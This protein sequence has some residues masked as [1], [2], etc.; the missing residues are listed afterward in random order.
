MKSPQCLAGAIFPPRSLIRNSRYTLFALLAV[1]VGASMSAQSTGSATSPASSSTST[2]GKN[3]E[4]LALSPFVVRTERDDGFVAA[5]SLAGGRLGGDLKDTPVAYSVLTRDFIDALGLT[6]LAEMAQWAPNTSEPRNMGNLEWS[7]NDFYLASRGV[8]ANRPQRDFF[9]YGFNFDSYNIE[10][11]DFGRGPNSILFGNS[12]YGS[13]PNIVSKRARPDKRMSE[14]KVSYGSWENFRATLD[15]NQPLGDNAALRFN[16]LHL[17]RKGWQDRDFEKKNSATLAGTWQPLKNTELRFEAE[18]GEKDKAAVASNFDDFI[19][20][21]NGVNTYSA[22][23]SA[24]V[25]AAGIGR[26]ATRTIV[27]TPTNGLDT[28]INYEGWARTEGGNL[29]ASY[30]AGGQ[31]VPGPSA[32]IRNTPILNRLN[33]PATLFDLAENGSNFRVPTREFTTTVDAPLYTEDYY[34]YTFSVTQQFGERLFAEAAVNFAGLD[35]R[36]DIITSRGLTQVYIDVNRVLP[37]GQT[38]PNF[39][40]PYSESRSYPHN[41]LGEARNGRLALAYVLDDT[42][43]GDFRFNVLAGTSRADDDQETWIYVL[44]DNADPRQWPTF[45]QVRFRYYLN[46]DD[47]RPYDTSDRDWTYVNPITNT[48]QTVAGGLVRE[49]G[50]ATSNTESRTEYDYV[51]AAVDAKFFKKRLNLLAAVRRDGYSTLQRVGINQFDYPSTWDGKTL[52]LKPDAPGDW[53]S[54]TYRQRDTAG[55]PV[56]P[57]LLADIRPRLSTGFVDPRYASD[58]FQDDFNAPQIEGAINTFS[59]GG[60]FHVT[61]HVSVF[62]NYAE[63]FVPPIARYDITGRLIDARSAEGYDFGLRFRMLNGRLVANLIRYEGVD[64]GNII[65]AAAYRSE[66]AEIAQANPVGDLTPSGLNARGLPV[67]PNG[68]LDTVK[69]EISGWEF[70]VTANLTKNW[71]L[72]LN[73]ALAEGYQTDTYPTVQAYLAANDSVL[74]QIVQDAGGVFNGDVA[75]YNTAIPVSTSPEGPGAVDA[76]NTTRQLLA[77]ISTEKQKLNRLVEATGNVFTDY[78][79]RTGMLKGLRVGAGAN[80]R[81]KQVIGYRGADT[82]RN[83]ANTAQ[84]IDDPTVGPLDVVYQPAYTTATATLNYNW[85]VNRKLTVDLSLRISNLFDYAKPIYFST[86]LRPP[87]GDLTNPARVSTPVNYFWITPRNYTLSATVKF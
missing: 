49:F 59:A 78:T 42:K 18:R 87:D 15:H 67:P 85:R 51:Q 66:I 27:F 7:N 32:N 53:S 64:K 10:R 33:L 72:T 5:T 21:W 37:N 63:S 6:D 4:V 8:S 79:F 36:G 38:N 44:K 83:P 77:S 70:E 14:V 34:N 62:A 24:A 56:G 41:R 47:V 73:G 26:Q 55:N 48:T 25:A 84:A 65:S 74:R 16:A 80:Y 17:D 39:L 30:P 13:T 58:R 29:N 22:R 2:L 76:W 57:A 28:L 46:T 19:S 69:S 40:E 11:L 61:N 31:L 1:A 20:A 68:I 82:I 71:R 23:I 35:K 45:N 81:G 75:T 86:T 54:L 9:P 3:D 60:V 50:S 43:L 52:T 12:G